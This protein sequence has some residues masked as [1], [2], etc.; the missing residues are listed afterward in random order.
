MAKLP[1]DFQSPPTAPPSDLRTIPIGLALS[2][3]GYRAAA[4]HLG[5][6]AY[7]EHVGLL[8][9]LSRLSTVSG[10]TFTGARYILSLL[11]KKESFADFFNSFYQF[12][13]RPSLLAVYQP[14]TIYCL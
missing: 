13:C 4:F 1:Y 10:G 14:R 5:T 2:G 8:P 12:L 6:M 11:E 7:L 9:Q 3:G